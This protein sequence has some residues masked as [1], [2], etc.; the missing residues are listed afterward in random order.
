L[1]KSIIW[2]TNLTEDT[3]FDLLPD[4]IKVLHSDY[5]L[6]LTNQAKEIL[7][8]KERWG[9]VSFVDE[10]IR[11]SVGKGPNT[12]DTV[13]HEVLHILVKMFD[14][15][16]DDEEHVVLTLATGLVTV[17]KDNPD[18]FPALQMIIEHE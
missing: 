10:V 6:D 18:L 11:V 4:T 17:M 14:L 15:K 9:E 8:A 1:L 16:V 12:A 3:V 7:D 13:I 5:K 2:G